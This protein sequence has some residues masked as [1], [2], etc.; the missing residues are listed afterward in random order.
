[1]QRAFSLPFMPYSSFFASAVTLYCRNSVV[2]LKRSSKKKKKQ[3]DEKEEEEKERVIC[4]M[5]RGERERERVV[6]TA[7]QAAEKYCR[8][9]KP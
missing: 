1:M 5:T 3:E 7:A 4:L 6:M 2:F 9:Q 8:T